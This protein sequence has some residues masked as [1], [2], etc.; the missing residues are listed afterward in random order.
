MKCGVIGGDV[1]GES[2]E[3]KVV[4]FGDCADHTWLVS[5]ARESE[6]RA[7]ATRK[8]PGA[9]LDSDGF[10]GLTDA[11][12]CGIYLPPLFSFSQQPPATRRGVLDAVCGVEKFLNQRR[13]PRWR[14][15]PDLFR[16]LVESLFE[17]FLLSFREL[18]LSP[19][20]MSIGQSV[21]KRFARIESHEPAVDRSSAEIPSRWSTEYTNSI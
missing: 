1:L 3:E 17:L 13:H 18:S 11:N 9:R 15:G 12:Y 6:A 19:K 7:R 21:F 20:S 5:S 16:R 2:G 8:T 4:V 14:V 10:P